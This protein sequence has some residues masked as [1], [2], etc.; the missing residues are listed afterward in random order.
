M[1]WLQTHEVTVPYYEVCGGKQVFAIELRERA[2][3][4]EEL[5][6]NWSSITSA[7]SQQFLLEDDSEND[8]MTGNTSGVRVAALRSY[9]Q[10]RKLWR[11]LIRATKTPSTASLA[12]SNSAPSHQDS[13]PSLAIPRAGSDF[14][15]SCR[16]RN[17]NCAF[18]SFHLFLKSY[19]FP[20]KLVMKRNTPSVLENRRQGL[21]L[22]VTT[23]RGL[24]DTFP[25]P[26]LQGFEE[27]ENCHVL[28]LLNAFFGFKEMRQV[29]P[30]ARTT[31]QLPSGRLLKDSRCSSM[32]SSVLS[33]SNTAFSTRSAASSSDTWS[34]D[35][36][37]DSTGIEFYLRHDQEGS[38]DTPNDDSDYKLRELDTSPG[39]AAKLNV[40][41]GDHAAMDRIGAK[42]RTL[43]RRSD[44][45]PKKLA[46][47]QT[48]GRRSRYYRGVSI[49]RHTA[50]LARNPTMS[51]RSCSA[52]SDAKAPQTL[53]PGLPKLQ[54]PTSEVTSIQTFLEEFRDHLLLDS[55]ALGSSGTS[56]KGWNEDRQWEL[57]LYVASQIGHVY[58][59]ESI[60]YRGT[61][62]NAVMEDGLSSLH[63]ACRGGNRSIVAMLLTY[64]ADT[65]LIDANG[66]S[67]LLSAVQLGDLEIVEML[68]EF[69]ANVNLCN[70]DS[71]S[72]AHVAVACQALPILQLLLEF[73]AFVN[74]ANSFNGK[75]PL[76][77]AAQCGS[78]P[79]C[80]QLM[81]YGGNIHHKT[82]RGL[83]VVALAKSHGHENVA[84]FCLSF[85][86]RR[87]MPRAASESS[88]APQT[89]AG[90][91]TSESSEVTI[92]SED[93]YAYAVL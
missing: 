52:A 46:N 79:M 14:S 19:P 73:D 3:R 32:G 61:N 81:Q 67:P 75:T 2:L 29:S 58:A 11:D 76:H 44:P 74:T 55:R 43:P 9:S 33:E 78:I 23:V 71:V 65:N 42:I 84:R 56:L 38:N 5:A 31:L 77:L 17:W 27:R 91:S 60:L 4:Q 16:C 21:E 69:G 64:G 28:A 22:F 50:F 92:V 35:Q 37:W 59:V 36:V 30:G 48:S 54:L 87:V 39:L 26:F 88:K 70:A 89:A 18:R 90:A 86:K 72:A 1:S 40:N 7:S 68:V 80:E 13:T 41:S 62:P 8:S 93:G 66:A 24:F 25:R 63:A 20:S 15:A 12:R 51:S 34:T 82:A 10:F 57:A 53:L 45:S 6:R 49:R 47:M 85:G 83:D